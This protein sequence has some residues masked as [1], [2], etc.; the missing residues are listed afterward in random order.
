M[1]ILIKSMEKGSVTMN[2]KV[3]KA[4]ADANVVRFGE[5]KLASGLNSPI[6]VNLRVLLSHPESMKIIGDELSKLVKKLKPD[7]VAGAE[8]AGIPLSTAISLKTGIPMIYV[9]KK[10]KT[11]G[12][13]DL[14][15]GILEK[16][17]KVVLVDDMA[18]N[19]FSKL[20]FIEGIKHAGGIIRDVVIVLDREQGG[21]EALGKE[22]IKL[23]SLITLKELLGYM[24]DNGM[25]DDAKLK[26]ILEYL[27]QN[28]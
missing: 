11:Y 15:E 22:D 17:R 6:Y 12:T 26:E 21:K 13:M 8:T 5:F 7:V 18:T 3:A 16:G 1:E 25:I 10:P 28:K 19:A 27:K 14:V 23:H 20:K 4:L 2:E 24:K 9:R